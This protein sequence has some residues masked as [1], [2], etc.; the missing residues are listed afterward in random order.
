MSF[1]TELRPVVDLTMTIVQ[2]RLR[3]TL[4]AQGHVNTGKLSQSIDYQIVNDEKTI[5]G[6]MFFADYGI[7]VNVG[8]RADRVRYPIRVMVEWFQQR[9]LSEREATRAAWATRAVH[10][11][12]GIPTR[13]SAR[14]SETGE[15]TRFV[16]TTI[17][18]QL[19][20]IAQIIDG[21]IGAAIA[22]EFQR[23][24]QTEKIKIFA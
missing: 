2:R 19:G 24:F 20:E 7:F 4:A 10:Q 22:I 8:V 14:F 9:G 3:E 1:V 12:E 16:E 17:E 23:V 18:S 5:I 21:R 15:R 11:R 6:R 13:A